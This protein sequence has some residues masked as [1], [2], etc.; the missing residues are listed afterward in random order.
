MIR[1]KS[2]RVHATTKN[3][4]GTTAYLCRGDKRYKL[5]TRAT[6]DDY[7]EVTCANCRKILLLD[8]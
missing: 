2:K 1:Y 4:T 6:T 3:I 8:R 7:E 5:D